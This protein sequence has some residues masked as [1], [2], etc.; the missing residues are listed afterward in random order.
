MEK[1][2]F[3]QLRFNH[4]LTKEEVEDKYNELLAY[5]RRVVKELEFKTA[6]TKKN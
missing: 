2:T 1:K 3:A 6:G 4:T 5:H